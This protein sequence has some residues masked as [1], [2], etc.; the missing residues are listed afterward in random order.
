M[1]MPAVYRKMIFTDAEREEQASYIQ[2]VIMEKQIKEE[3][4]FY[5]AHPHDNYYRVQNERKKAALQVFR[6]RLKQR[7]KV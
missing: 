1:A 6:E 5:M 7:N 3:K 4:E 2:A